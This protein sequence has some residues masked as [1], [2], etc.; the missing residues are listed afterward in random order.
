MPTP[1]IRRAPALAAGALLAACTASTPGSGPAPEGT[2]MASTDP[3]SGTLP[4]IP[5]VRGPLRIDVVYPAEDARLTASDSN[6][7]FG[8]VG[9][10]EARLTINGDAVEVAPNGAFL[11]FVP[12]PRDGVYRVAASAGAEQATAVRRIR[13]PAGAGETAAGIAALAPRAAMT[14]QRGERVTVR[15][16]GAP[17]GRARIVFPDGSTAPLVETRT[18]ERDEGFLQDRSATREYTQYAGSFAAVAPLLSRDRQVGVPTLAET[19]RAGTATIE[20]VHGADTV[21]TPL[22]LSLAVLGPGE[23]RTAIA[24]SDRPDSLTVAT[25]I[26]GSG[27]PYHW[28]FPNGTRFTLTGERE[29]AYRV[30]LTEDQS[31]WVDARSVRLLPAGA[32]EARGTIGAVRVVP[33][34]EWVDLRLAMTERLPARVLLEGSFLTVEVFGGESRTNW[35]Y[36]GTEDPFVRRATWEQGRDDLYY[37]RMELASPAWGWRTF[38]DRDGTLVVRVRRP[39]AIDARRPLAGIHVAVDAGH[40]PGGAIGP[41]R[42]TEAEA[43]LAISKQLVRMLRDAGAR[44]TETRPDSAAVALGVRPVMAEQAGA[45]LLVSVHNNAFPD[46]VNPFTNSGTT[47]FYNAPQS[48]DLARHMQREILRELGLRDLGIAR[49]DLALV[50]PTWMPSTLTESMFLMVP[51][52]EAALRNPQVH[53]RIARAHFR[54]VEAFLRE[55]AVR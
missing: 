1:F 17:G 45:Q 25:A 23:T 35:L 28:T 42:L 26:P 43:N 31:V 5:A 47:A 20:L 6:F 15:F 10:G 46:G 18:L 3:L 44:V 49:A 22:E 33:Q 2:R 50:R 4:P 37:V 11:A 53:E 48:L 19:G 7:V 12:V 29:G 9:T 39:P 38:Y 24:A 32:P 34:A 40:P 8:S 14:V 41:T 51:Q 52:Q 21:R 27:T 54:A 16:R 30:R 55:R 36:Y 13:L